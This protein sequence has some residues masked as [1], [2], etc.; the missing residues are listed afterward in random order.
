MAA[1]AAG[2]GLFGCARHSHYSEY[3]YEYRSE[4][5]PDHPYDRQ[6]SDD[7]DSEYKMVSPGEMKGR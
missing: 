7:L 2:M 4:P 5:R 6:K 3:N 1:A